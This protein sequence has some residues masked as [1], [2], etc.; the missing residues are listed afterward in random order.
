MGCVVVLGEATEVQ[1]FEL[2]GAVVMIAEGPEEVRQSWR[3]LPET[4]EVV[5]LTARA[6][7]ALR[8][9]LEPGTRPLTTVMP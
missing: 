7:A 8:D 9:D 5:V 1:G 2:A 6:A 4:A 3:D